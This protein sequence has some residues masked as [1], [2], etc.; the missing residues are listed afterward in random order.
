MKTRRE[1]FHKWFNRDF[2]R[3]FVN[4]T[5]P[6]EIPETKVDRVALVDR[7]FDE[8]DSARY[9]PSIPE[10][11]MLLNKGYGVTRTV[12]VF[13]ITDYIVYYFCVKELENILAGNRTPNTF[14]GWLLG[15][16][17]RSKEYCEIDCEA[18]DYGRYSFNPNGWRQAF[19]EFNALLYAQ[20]DTV[21]YSYVL[22]FDLSNFYDSIRLD[23][24]ERMIREKDHDDKG[25]VITLLFY[26]LNHWN[27]KNTG[28]HRQTVGL[29]QDALADCSRLLAN[30]Y[31]QQYDE[32]AAR[33]C[34]KVDGAYFRYADDQMI[35]I[36]NTSKCDS[37]LLLLTRK[38]DRF[39]LRVN[40]KKVDIWT[41]TEIQENRCRGVHAIFA[42]QEDLKNGDVVKE[43]AN[44]YLS[45]SKEKLLKTWNRGMPMLNRLVWA[46]IESLAEE[47][48]LTVVQ[49]LLEPS[50]LLLADSKK[51]KRI[52]DI[53]T[54]HAKDIRYRDMLIS[55]GDVSVH[56]AFHHEV[57]AY[58]RLVNDQ[59][60]GRIF[61]RRIRRL[62]KQMNGDEIS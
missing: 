3:A 16:K 45:I 17:L 23:T 60:L 34:H 61:K 25:W 22:Q 46:N 6:I 31:L 7:V 55:L 59:E 11:E 20:L 2:W 56:N 48:M 32:F 62:E 37:I 36:N 1:D 10:T 39:G 26:L 15:G 47:Q 49:R 44:K 42:N 24:L 8:I 58:A 43:Y 52:S 54:R 9:S 35:L 5:F 13:S 28:L 57:V 38:L 18:T 4:R 51:L 53:V 41:T 19:G 21:R 29:P 30:F 14:G 40:Q 27:R 50:Y 33:V 12:P